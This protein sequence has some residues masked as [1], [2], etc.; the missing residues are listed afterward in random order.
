MP[1]HQVVYSGEHLPNPLL[2]EIHVQLE[3]GGKIMHLMPKEAL[4]WRAAEYGI[5]PTD[6]D[7]LMEVL[8]HEPF[9]PTQDQEQADPALKA[10]AKPRLIDADNTAQAKADHLDR[11]KNCPAKVIV[12]GSKALDP[13]RQ[14]HKANP[15]V[16]KQFAQAVDVQR[17]THKY[18][19]L[20]LPPV[21]RRVK[22]N[23]VPIQ[24]T[25]MS[26][27]EVT[28]TPDSMISESTGVTIRVKG[29]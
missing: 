21:D 11:V 18:G 25:G 19:D 14:G 1:T 12:R 8:L 23:G 2:W 3:G 27:P 24:A 17:W 16:V 26:S 13:I 28:L 5:D 10:K 9:L 15:D 29:Q 22:M 20:P 7:T 6:V 4:H